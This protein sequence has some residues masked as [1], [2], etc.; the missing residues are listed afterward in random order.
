L[1]GKKRTGKHYPPYAGCLTR[2]GRPL[3]PAALCAKTKPEPPTR[4]RHLWLRA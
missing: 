2:A 4:C 3:L 1:A